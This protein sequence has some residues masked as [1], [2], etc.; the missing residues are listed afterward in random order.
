M[1]TCHAE[2]VPEELIWLLPAV[3]APV[4]WYA[5]A[6]GHRRLE[7][8]AKPLVLVLLIVAAVVLGATDTTA[9]RWLLVAL[10]FG[11]VGDIALLGESNRHFLVGLA[12]FLVGHLA[13]VACFV[14]LGLPM[15]W[16]SWL[17]PVALAVALVATRRVLPEAY[18]AAGA[19]LAV[20]VGVYMTVI[21]AMLICAWFTGEWLVAAGAT[22]FAASDGTLSVNKFVRPVP[23]ARLAIMVTY[24]VGQGLIVLGVLAAL[25]G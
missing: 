14:V 5:A 23:H 12:A 16:W 2:R 18:R 7:V 1:R 15:P 20:P 22:V 10:F 25:G 3:A 8:V 24:H 11:L 4:D 21:G 6:R 19:K 9:G 13:F 17:G